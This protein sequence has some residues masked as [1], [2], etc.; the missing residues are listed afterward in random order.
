MVVEFLAFFEL[1]GFGVLSFAD[2]FV[3]SG[4]FQLEADVFE[5]LL[6][7]VGL[8]VDGVVSYWDALSVSLSMRF[9][10]KALLYKR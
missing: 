8:Y 5:G 1:L 4:C 9:S 2:G 10:P 7:A 3:T 6:D